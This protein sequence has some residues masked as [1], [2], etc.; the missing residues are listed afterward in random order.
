MPRVAEAL[1]YTITGSQGADDGGIRDYLGSMTD[2]LTGTFS[3]LNV[4]IQATPLPES[5]KPDA[6]LDF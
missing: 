5:I 3:S 6:H 2:M 4:Q 1:M